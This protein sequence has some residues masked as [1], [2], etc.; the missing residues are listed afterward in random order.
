[1]DS[2]SNTII[3]TTTAKTMRETCD[4]AIACTVCFNF[5]VLAVYYLRM[6]RVESVY[7]CYQ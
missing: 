3:F 1:M 2:I 6:Y 7:V 4:L 5:G